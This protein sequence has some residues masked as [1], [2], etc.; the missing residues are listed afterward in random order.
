MQ[1]STGDRSAFLRSSHAVSK[2]R[3]PLGP[4]FVNRS[5]PNSTTTLCHQ[6][7][8]DLHHRQQYLMIGH[9]TYAK[10]EYVTRQVV[11]EVNLVTDLSTLMA[12]VDTWPTKG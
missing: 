9:M 7:S 1:R 4:L 5:T 10:P 2:T 6:I 3:G 11:R 12:E 8:T